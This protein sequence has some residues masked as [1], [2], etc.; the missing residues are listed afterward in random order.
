[1]I[2]EA[3]SLPD[4]L[5]IDDTKLNIFPSAAGIQHCEVESV[6]DSYPRWWPNKW[7]KSWNETIR[8]AV[9]GA[10]V[11]DSVHDR[12]ALTSIHKCGKQE[13][14]RPDSLRKDD[15]FKHYFE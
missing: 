13:P 10:P 8:K 4:P 9:W 12:F 14:Y 15:R 1:M 2:D 5:K 7:R 6:R 3:R 11:H